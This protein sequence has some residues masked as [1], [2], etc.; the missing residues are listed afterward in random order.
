[1]REILITFLLFGLVF[2]LAS[3]RYKQ[4]S[5]KSV[6]KRDTL[7]NDRSTDAP[8]PI[9]ENAFQ[10][11]TDNIISLAEEPALAKDVTVVT[12]LLE[13]EPEVAIPLAASLPLQEA[14]NPENIKADAVPDLTPHTSTIVEPTAGSNT[15]KAEDRDHQSVLEEIA[16]LGEGS[17]ETAIATLRR[18]VHHS[19]PIVRATA[20]KTLGELVVKNQ[21]QLQEEMVTLLNELLHDSNSEVQLQAAAALGN[22]PLPGSLT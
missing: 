18:H 1:M 13:P 8:Q 9:G 20:A 4:G 15:Q 16:H 7:T 12:P 10:P 2:L 14:I 5:P 19:N 3:T 6:A 21:G 17:H 11:A 22:R